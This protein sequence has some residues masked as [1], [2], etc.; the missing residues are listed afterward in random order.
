[1]WRMRYMSSVLKWP[2]FHR[3]S[4]R[5]SLLG[6]AWKAFNTISM[7]LLSVMWMLSTPLTSFLDIESIF[8]FTAWLRRLAVTSSESVWEGSKPSELKNLCSTQYKKAGW[9]DWNWVSHSAPLSENQNP[10]NLLSRRIE[11][12]IWMPILRRVWCKKEH[13]SYIKSWSLDVLFCANPGSV[14]RLRV[15]W[16]IIRTQHLRPAAFAS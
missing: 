8:Q 15:L 14:A 3:H 2:T 16:S 1:M 10:Q 9:V 4:S 6:H 7:A 12:C 5:E 13:L 11:V